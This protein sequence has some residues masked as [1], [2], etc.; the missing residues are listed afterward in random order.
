M[1]RKKI[2]KPFYFLKSK[3]LSNLIHHFDDVK[4]LLVQRNKERKR[5]IGVSLTLSPCS[6]AIDDAQ[7]VFIKT[8]IPC[9]RLFS[10]LYSH[11]P[12][13]RYHPADPAPLLHS[14]SLSIQHHIVEAS[15]LTIFDSFFL[16][17]LLYNFSPSFDTFQTL[18]RVT[19][20][21]CLQINCE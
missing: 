20:I 6:F 15:S 5:S 17:I 11:A 18:V 7:K 1:T 14:Q 3:R 21:Y 8:D 9:Y 2:Q 12:P 16:F 10:S 4:Y 13:H 19:M